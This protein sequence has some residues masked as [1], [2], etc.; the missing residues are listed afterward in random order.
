M[1]LCAVGGDPVRDLKLGNGADAAAGAAVGQDGAAARQLRSSLR[2][3]PDHS[4]GAGPTA[5]GP[6]VS[7]DRGDASIVV[8]I[9]LALEHRPQV[10]YPAGTRRGLDAFVG[11]G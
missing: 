7:P 8:P 2:P 9:E 10:W 11:A 3:R 5:S 1:S 4:T 6:S